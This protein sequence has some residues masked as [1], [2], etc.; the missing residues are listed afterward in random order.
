MDGRR[1][2]RMVA[3]MAWDKAQSYIDGPLARI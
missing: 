3:K 2:G 1:A